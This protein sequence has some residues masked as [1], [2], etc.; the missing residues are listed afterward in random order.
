MIRTIITPAQ[1]NISI[2]LPMNFVGKKV[3][4]LLYILEEVEVPPSAAT[5]KKKPS[6]Y[7]GS[8]SLEAAN[9]LLSYIE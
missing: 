6:D 2:H 3:E 7:A 9:E 8:L 4:V 5:G 1:Q